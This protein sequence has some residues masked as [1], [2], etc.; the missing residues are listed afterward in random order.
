MNNKIMSSGISTRIDYMVMTD[1]HN[2]LDDIIKLANTCQCQHL[3][4]LLKRGVYRYR[5]I[6]PS[7]RDMELG[8]DVGFF[9]FEEKKKVNN[10][11]GRHLAA[12]KT[13]AA[14]NKELAEAITGI[15]CK[16]LGDGWDNDTH[17][18]SSSEEEEEEE[19]EELDSSVEVLEEIEHDAQPLPEEPFSLP[20]SPSLLEPEAESTRQ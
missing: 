1:I 20:G 15:I 19:A 5:S 11:A 7:R 14:R 4:T 17:E 12:M 13:L 9:V 8:C 10:W 2:L 6:Y 18:E 3:R 16:H